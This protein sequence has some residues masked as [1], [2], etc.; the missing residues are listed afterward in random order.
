MSTQTHAAQPITENETQDAV[1]TDTA[2]LKSCLSKKI[3]TKGPPKKRVRF[4]MTD[5]KSARTLPE[6]AETG[7]VIVKLDVINEEDGETDES[8]TLNDCQELFSDEDDEMAV[9]KCPDIGKQIS[10]VQHFL[11]NERLKTHKKRKI[12]S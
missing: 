8:L 10:Q 12:Q 4:S 6:K 7:P 5:N 1:T 11:D 3:K 2:I 9:V